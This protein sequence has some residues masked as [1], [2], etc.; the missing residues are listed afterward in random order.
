MSK[1]QEETLTDTKPSGPLTLGI[2]VV[3]GN[4]LVY[5]ILRQTLRTLGGF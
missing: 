1:D 5:G 3:F 2:Y 4:H